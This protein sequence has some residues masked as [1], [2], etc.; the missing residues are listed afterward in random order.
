[1][2][3]SP[4]K[5]RLTLTVGVIGHRPNRLPSEARV[6]VA[7]QVNETFALIA[8]TARDARER[9]D[10][11]FTEEPPA[12][13]C[14]SALAEGA[15]RIAAISALENGYALNAILP[16]DS[17]EYAL[18]F[19]QKSSKREYQMLLGRATTTLALPGARAYEPLAYNT[20]GLTIVDNAD[21]LLAVWD[22][23]ESAGSGGTTELIERAAR[24][25]LP[26]IYL[27][28]KGEQEPRVIW[29]GLAQ[30]PASG[31]SILEAPS[32][33][34]TAALPSVVEQIVRPPQDEIETTKLSNYL[35]ETWKPWNWR[36]EF[37][38]LF[39][40]LGLRPLRKADLRPKSPDTLAANLQS[41]TNPGR[42]QRAETVETGVLSQTALAYG[43]AD[44]LG[45]RYAQIF[46]GAYT[47]NFVCAALV[48][49][50]G[51]T[52]LVGTQLF[53]W[54]SWPWAA[55]EIAL[56]VLIFVN[57]RVGQKR[58]WHSRWRESREVAE[59][60]RAAKLL[61]LV[62]LSP[63]V[64]RANQATWVTWYVRAQTCGLGLESGT[65]DKA[66]L[67]EVRGSLI[68]IAE[69]QRSYHAQ[70]ADLMRRVERRIEHIAYVLIGLTILF[71]T[72][73]A[74][75]SFGWLDVTEEWNPLLMGLP[76]ALPALAAATFGIRLIGDFEGIAARDG[77]TSAT[78][79]NLVDALQQ[80]QP[81][82]ALLRS[83]ARSIVDALLGD[84][85]HWQMTTESRKLVEPV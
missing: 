1:M 83:R 25:G 49:F 21:I 3:A 46:R 18:D 36:L 39:A 19:K 72:I 48:V 52:S 75:I 70:N 56:V 73:N 40:I 54:S 41:Q 16:F 64:S 26:I 74:I 27:D 60:L 4:P 68:D 35:G 10:E 11:F 76:A 45:I 82:L 32:S 17:K 63:S 28:A 59:R 50:V 79:S 61:S 55:I 51:I 53:K 43:W 31:T 13:A 42:S 23:A 15:D 34:L 22:G 8:K 9:H 71:A 14:I 67:E 81:N 33:D 20:A 80:D 47:S 66:R 2:N 6:R 57:T 62:A 78:L 12:P 85:S 7:A 24:S 69:S 77:R 84:L 5:P 30:F 29:S 37:P 44:A 38:L 65:L 58:D